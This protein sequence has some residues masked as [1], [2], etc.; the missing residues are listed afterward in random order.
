MRRTIRTVTGRIAILCTAAIL[1][2]S[3]APPPPPP[4]GATSATSGGTVAVAPQPA[5]QQAAPGVVRYP[6]VGIRLDAM[7]TLN[8]WCGFLGYAYCRHCQMAE[9]ATCNGTFVS[10]C[11][12]GRD[13][14]MVTQRSLFDAQMCGNALHQADC[15]AVGQGM[16]PQACQPPGAN[17]PQIADAEVNLWTWCS[18]LSQNFCRNCSP[19][20]PDTCIDAFVPACLARRDPNMP[21]GRMRSEM[22]ACGL[23]LE[24]GDCHAVTQ[25]VLPP[26]C[27]PASQP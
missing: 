17:A 7:V 20:D 13:G 22:R 4:G 26:A 15:A 8:T 11:L 23:Q 25:G 19:E 16:L 24:S 27:R 12:A 6:G 14:T 9:L 5:P 2:C 1:G 21:T 10:S 18:S 3:A